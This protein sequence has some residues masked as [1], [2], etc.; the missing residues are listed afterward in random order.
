GAQA[1]TQDKAVAKTP[2]GPG[3]GREGAR[4]QPRR[5]ERR[6]RR[7]RRGGRRN[8][9]RDGERGY[10][11]T[12]QSEHSA[13]QEFAPAEQF[14]APA[15]ESEL[16]HGVADLD[17]PPPERAAPPDVSPD[18]PAAEQAETARRRS[19]IREPAPGAGNEAAG[20]DPW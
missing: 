12:D 13:Q 6:R 20:K 8:R 2:A 16:S 1:G 18:M 5:D 17:S 11:G 10:A 3:P 15:A 4:N 19:T 14:T 7:G 9:Q